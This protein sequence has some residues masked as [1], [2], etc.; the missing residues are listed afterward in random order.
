MTARFTGD[1]LPALL[2]E[3]TVHHCPPSQAAGLQS[4]GTLD[5]LRIQE[6]GRRP[7]SLLPLKASRVFSVSVWPGSGTLRGLS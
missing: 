7:R 6:P 5:V 1:G 4:P 2:P 3:P